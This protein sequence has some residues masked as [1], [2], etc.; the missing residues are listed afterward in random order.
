MLFFFYK[1]DYKPDLA[2]L[3]TLTY[4]MPEKGRQTGKQGE[5]KRESARLGWGGICVRNRPQASQITVRVCV[6]PTVKY[7]A[8]R[9]EVERIQNRKETNWER[10]QNE[11]SSNFS[12]EIMHS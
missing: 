12:N 5:S 4:S 1:R 6:W 10:K 3:F 11:G 9:R 7:A 2:E 8:S